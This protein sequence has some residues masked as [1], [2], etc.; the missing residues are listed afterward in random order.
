M[1][2][3][4]GLCVGLCFVFGISLATGQPATMTLRAKL[5]DF[6]D[7]S[8]TDPSSHPDFENDAFMACGGEN[9]GYV[10]NAIRLDGLVDTALFPGDNRDPELQLLKSPDKTMSCFT[11][12]D[13]FKDWY[14]DNPAVNRSFYTDIVLTRNAQGLFVFD[15]DEFLPLNAGA[16]YKKFKPTDPDPFGPIP[17]INATDVWGFTLELHTRF[18]YTAGKSQVFTF[19]GDDDVWVFIN[20]R[21]AIDL[22]GLH[23]ALTSTIDLDERAAE[24]GLTD[25]AAYPL[26][27]F[28]AERHSTGSHC[29][30][31]TSLQLVQKT[32]LPIPV[33]TPAGQAFR[34]SVRVSLSVPGVADAQ[35]RY[36]TNGSEP[37]ETSPLYAGG[38]SILATTTL[39]AKA[40]H[41]AYTPSPTLTEVYTFDPARLPTPVADPRGK[42]FP[43]E[44]SVTLS[45]PGNPE[46][47]IRVTLN[48]A[49]PDS[50][51]PLY[52]GTI[53]I[54]S[55][56]VV[57]AKAF[58]KGWLS[59]SVMVETYTLVIPPPPPPPPIP[60]PPPPPP[61]VVT[62][63]M[64]K[65]LSTP[66]VTPIILGSP[67]QGRPIAVV[68]GGAGAA[69][70]LACPPGADGLATQ[71]GKWPEWTATSR[72]PFHYAFWIYDNLGHFVVAQSGE[73]TQPMLEKSPADADGKR[74]FRFRWL[75][76]DG[77]GGAAGT[78]AYIL[79]AQVISAT[80]PAGKAPS[81]MSFVKTFGYLRG[82]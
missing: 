54:R 45:V 1:R 2:L 35:I 78:G 10:K 5:R 63:D 70:C 82:R 67:I 41:E 11:S 25:G 51:S 75:P 56:T 16:G 77:Q 37:T 34:D 6:K 36:T 66:D 74:A 8:P 22:G 26:D 32:P 12:F 42:E 47:E 55:T 50:A 17:S 81:E 62:L 72:D 76:V 80:T 79:K 52:T 58:R 28:F 23:S 57:K 44:L 21:L 3:P 65:A 33:A 4:V 59:S 68:S 29:R 39:K 14:N 69:E 24:L 40:F 9:L 71:D 31:T 49:D 46:A 19:K 43:T 73:V 15:D 48:G 53:P 30:I 60:P 18:T 64:K 13:K 20:G 27:F 38:I 61:N 7:Y